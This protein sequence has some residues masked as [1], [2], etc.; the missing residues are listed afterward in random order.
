MIPGIELTADE[1]IPVELS[2]LTLKGERARRTVPVCGPGAYTVLKALAFHDRA[3]PKDA[4]DLV[5]VLRR[6]PEGKTDIAQRLA[7]HAQ[8][9]TD[10][11]NRAIEAL[12]TD[13][14]DT[15]HLGPMRAA[16][17][18]T[19]DERYLDEAIADAHGHVDDL[20]TSCSRAGL[21]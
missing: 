19:L 8:Q 13:F 1:R 4:F 18:E 16:E 15:E 10:V 12:R 3:E 6:W 17:F 20:L 9:H 7:Q 2:G 14:R 11:D 21:S 5:Y